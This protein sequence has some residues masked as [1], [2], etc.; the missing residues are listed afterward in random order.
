METI[1][2]YSFREM[3]NKKIFLATLI[4][5]FLFLALYGG[6]LYMVYV[7]GGTPQDLVMKALISRQ[8]LGA[9]FYFSTFIVAFLAVLGSVSTV[10]SE[11]ET[12]VLYSILTKPITRTTYLWGKYL[13]LGLMLVCFS[14]LMLGSV[15]AI[16]LFFAGELMAIFSPVALGKAMAIYTLIPLCLLSVVFYLGTK[17]KSLATGITVIM[18][19]MLGIIG[20]FLEQIGV[21]LN[22]QE[23]VDI[24]ILASLLSPMDS[25]YRKF[26]SVLYGAG[27]IQLSLFSSGPF[28]TINPPSDWVIV[29]GIAFAA[30]FFF[31]AIRNF[32][33]LDL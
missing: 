20:G 32:K 27:D 17:L 3:I 14:I 8:L 19:F 15:I 5:A 31:L 16:N 21:V 28:G 6:A 1:I 30:I 9:G 25:I 29:Y 33:K 12:G 26:F 24:G 7:K 2:K 11:F 13:G 18:L 22:K 4:L 23:L 10:A